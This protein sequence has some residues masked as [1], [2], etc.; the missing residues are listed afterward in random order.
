MFCQSYSTRHKYNY[1]EYVVSFSGWHQLPRNLLSGN[2]NTWMYHQFSCSVVSDFLRPRGLQHTRLQSME[3]QRV[4]HDWATELNWTGCLTINVS[5]TVSVALKLLTDF[6]PHNKHMKWVLFL[7][8]FISEKNETK[9]L[10]MSKVT[11]QILWK[12]HSD[13]ESRFFYDN[14]H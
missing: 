3:S 9:A 11:Q 7:F 12:S 6:N 1:K 8:L 4:G 2:L 5:N 13:P 14:E 10:R